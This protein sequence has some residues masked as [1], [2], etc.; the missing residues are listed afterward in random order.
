MTGIISSSVWL[1]KN[2]MRRSILSRSGEPYLNPADHPN[3]EKNN[4]AVDPVKI[5]TSHFWGSKR[6]NNTPPPM[7]MKK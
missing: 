4:A 3:R 2:R 7:P 6:P 1:C 5:F